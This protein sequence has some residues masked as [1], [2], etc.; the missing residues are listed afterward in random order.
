MPMCFG[1]W[2]F[3]P[4]NALNQ[5]TF[6]LCDS[7]LSGLFSA[8]M[9]EGNV[10]TPALQGLIAQEGLCAWCEQGTAKPW[11]L[12]KCVC[13]FL[14]LVFNSRLVLESNHIVFVEMKRGNS[15]WVN[16]QGNV[17]SLC[18]LDVSPVLLSSKWNLL[19]FNFLIPSSHW[20]HSC[21]PI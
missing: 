14:R 12:E 19:S 6:Y 5:K 16:Q 7:G 11:P 15:T 21:K 13:G 9:L 17:G 3:N 1:L 18:F 8:S 2:N 10:E 4:L 20:V